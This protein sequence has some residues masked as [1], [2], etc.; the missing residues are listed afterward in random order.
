MMRNI[1]YVYAVI[2]RIYA[3][4]LSIAYV[5]SLIKTIFLAKTFLLASL[6]LPCLRYA[7]YESRDVSNKLPN[8]L[9]LL[10]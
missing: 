4:F 7:S 6:E 10:P 8:V 2:F 5:C 3:C 1:Y 9:L